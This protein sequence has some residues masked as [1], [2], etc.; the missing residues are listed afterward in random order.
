MP[1]MEF[2]TTRPRHPL[3]L[4]I[5]VSLLLHGAIL[6]LDASTRKNAGPVGQ[7]G[8]SQKRPRLVATLARPTPSTPPPATPQRPAATLRKPASSSKKPAA[9]PVLSAPNGAWAARAWSRDE[10]SEM[11]KFLNEPPPPA[12]PARPLAET[13]LA[14]ARQ[15]GHSQEGGEEEAQGAPTANGKPADRFSLELYFDAFVRK[16]NRSA[17][18]V[19]NDPRAMGHRK[20]LV[21]ISL[22]PDGSLKSYKVL[23]AADQQ[24]EI[25]YIKSVLERAA[26]FSAF[27]ADIRSA[28]DALN[29]QMCIYPPNANG[30]SGFSRS[31]SAQDCR[32]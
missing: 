22:N 18:F 9:R 3:R 17:A 29:I 16:M 8:T 21:Q 11:D 25:A 32:D 28:T 19:K 24:A 5:L 20:A 12:P 6:W 26:P 14:M 23:R 1:G 10:R 4:A 7:S 2:R 15:L 13:A 31:F 30:N 27:P